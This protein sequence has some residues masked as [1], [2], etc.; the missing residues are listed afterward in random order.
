MSEVFALYEPESHSYQEFTILF[1]EV[2]KQSDPSYSKVRH[3]WLTYPKYVVTPE[4]KSLELP[5]DLP[6]LSGLKEI[7]F[8]IEWTTIVRVFARDFVSQISGT[9]KRITDAVEERIS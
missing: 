9:Q 3:I 6:E 7:V 5:N 2:P 4:W 1:W 8:Q